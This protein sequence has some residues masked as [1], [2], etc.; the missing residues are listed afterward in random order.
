V[1]QQEVITLQNT[2]Q[3]M[4]RELLEANNKIKELQEDL[5]SIHKELTEFS[6][7]FEE[8]LEGTIKQRES[9]LFA[10]L[11]E[12]DNV[13]SELAST[14]AQLIFTTTKLKNS[15]ELLSSLASGLLP[16]LKYL[17][18]DIQTKAENEKSLKTSLISS[19]D[20]VVKQGTIITE[21]AV[22]K[23]AYAV[24]QEYLSDTDKLRKDNIHLQKEI[25]EIRRERQADRSMELDNE[26]DQQAKIQAPKPQLFTQGTLMLDY[27][28]LFE[29][30]TEE[31]KHSRH[32]SSK[33]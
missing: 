19:I 27:P 11:Q 14:K 2:N 8:K 21:E 30:N 12:L 6:N 1:A 18:E 31:A 26:I 28:K 10:K 20:E 15:K 7:N 29:P 4:E 17:A 5:A 32:P 33:K 25:D 3:G 9:S 23:A 24:T 13:K 16:K 22:N